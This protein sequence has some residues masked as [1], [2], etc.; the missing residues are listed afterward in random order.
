MIGGQKRSRTQAEPAPGGPKPDV[1]TYI[2]SDTVIDGSVKSKGPVRVDGTVHGIVEIGG[3]LEVAAS[4]VIEGDQV[5]AEHVKI[6]G[7]VKANVSATGRIEIWRSGHLE[8]DVR[9]ASLDIEDGATFIGR[10]EMNVKPSVAVRPAG[11]TPPQ[12]GP[13]RG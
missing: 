1:H 3:L 7:R 10:S 8:G 12:T 2:H 4:G 9:A 11:H 13:D 6:L 5:T